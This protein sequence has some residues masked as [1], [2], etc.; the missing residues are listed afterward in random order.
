MTRCK[1]PIEFNVLGDVSEMLLRLQW[2]L[3]NLNV[4]YQGSATR[5]FNKVQQHGNGRT[6]TGT[7]RTEDDIDFTVILLSC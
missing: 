2:E 6:F 4:V 1:V 5:R 7:V 3:R